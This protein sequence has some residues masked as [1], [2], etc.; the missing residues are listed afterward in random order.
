MLQRDVSKGRDGKHKKIVGKL[1]C[2]IERLKAGSALKIPRSALPD[3]KQNIR[4]ALSRASRQRGI[5]VA[6]SSGFHH[7]Y[8]WEAES[9][10]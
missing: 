8:I 7:P 10:P 2:E 1:L 9:K 4:S 3:T 6:T 5:E